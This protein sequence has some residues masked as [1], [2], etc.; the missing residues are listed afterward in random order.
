M[1][2]T[3]IIAALAILSLVAIPALGQMTDYQKGIAEGLKV[4]FFMHEKYT[5][6]LDGINVSGYNAE[7]DRYNTWIRSIF[8]NDPQFLMTPITGPTSIAS[9]PILI[10]NT[11]NSTSGIVHEI[12]GGIAKGPTY[13]TNDMNLLPESQTNAMLNNPDPL[14]RQGEYLGGV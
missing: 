6:A 8:G 11:S 1:K 4:G 9:K 2:L 3:R 7:V 5:Q 12:D 14:K 13:K 10:T